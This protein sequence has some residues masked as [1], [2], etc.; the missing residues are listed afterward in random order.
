MANIYTIIC[1]MEVRNLKCFSKMFLKQLVLCFVVRFFFPIYNYFIIYIC[2]MM[3]PCQAAEFR[4]LW[5][6]RSELR[7]FQDGAITEAVLWEGT[8]MCQ[9][10]LVPR[11]IVTHLLQL[12]VFYHRET[13]Q[14][15]HYAGNNTVAIKVKML[16]AVIIQIFSTICCKRN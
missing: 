2:V 16:L 11:Q 6:S 8:N 12:Y 13:Q 5:G 3:T 14:H 7:R 1:H 9:K 15:S 10:Q 4:Q